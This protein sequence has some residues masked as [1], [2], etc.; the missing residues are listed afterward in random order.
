MGDGIQDETV[1]AVEGGVE[2]NLD[3]DAPVLSGGSHGTATVLAAALDAG[4]PFEPAPVQPQ[5]VVAAA[6]LSDWQAE[7]YSFTAFQLPA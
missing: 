3:C 6:D 2:S 4:K 7:P 1:P 5:T